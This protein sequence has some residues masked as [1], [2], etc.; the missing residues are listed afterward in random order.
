MKNKIC[1][2]LSTYNG[3][4]FLRKQIE[5]ILS[6][7]YKNF[8]ILIRDDGST[9]NTLK[10]LEEYK[11][12]YIKGKN[13]GVV[14]SFLWLLEYG[15]KEGY[16]Y[17]L[18]CDQDD[19]W[20]YDKIEKQMSLINTTKQN[21]PVLIHSDMQIIDD[22]EN[23]ISNSFFKF[24]KLDFNKKS[25]NY[26]LLQ[27]NITGN[28]VLINKNLAKL[29]KFHKNIIMH[30]WWIGLIASAFGRIYFINEALLKYRKHSQ[31][32]IG[33]EKF[34]DINKI[35]KFID[36]SF[37]DKFLQIKAFKKLYYSKL[38]EENKYIIDKFLELQ[39]ENFFYKRYNIIR[40]EFF[41]QNIFANIGMLWKI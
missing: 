10:I 25:L 36:Y 27:N 29:I 18:F 41:M 40:N 21:I 38:N 5:S 13:I 24:S 8:D 20:N 15:L 7:S 35:K 1:I 11:L 23:I 30:D 34:F 9:D 19:I 16:E 2:L 4:N 32:V 28:S 12:S 14:K 3:E 37:Q 22:N 39:G 33:A 17:F 26:L 6:Q 31:N